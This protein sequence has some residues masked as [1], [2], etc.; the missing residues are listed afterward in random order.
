VLYTAVARAAPDGTG[1]WNLDERV[2]LTTAIRAATI[3]SALANFAEGN[4]GNLTPGKYADLVVLSRDLFAA[5]DPREILDTSVT[6][7]VVAG[8]VVHR[9]GG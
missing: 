4:R 3:G 1:A 2:D 6:H 5:E 8:R 7:T 9:A